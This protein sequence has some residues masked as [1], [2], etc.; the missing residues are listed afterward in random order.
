MSIYSFGS[1]SLDADARVLL[2]DGEPVPTAGKTLDTLLVL[3]KNAGRLIDKDEFLSLLWPDTVV[4][5]ANLTQ[6]ISTV[7]RVLGD[8][9][10]HHRYIATVA[11]RG[12]QFVAPVTESS[13]KAQQKTE[14]PAANRGKRRRISA[15]LFAIAISL[16]LLAGVILW[17]EESSH[18]NPTIPRQPRRLTSRPGVETMPAFSP[19]GGRLAYVHSER[20][21]FAMHFLRSQSA[22]ANIYIK[23]VEAGTE[24]QLTKHAGADYH[25]AW[26]ADGEYL[27]FYRYAPGGSGYYTISALGGPERRITDEPAD[28]AGIAWVPEEGRLRHLV[29]ASLSEGSHASP[30]TEISVETGD[31]R[32][33]TFPP[34]RTLGDAWPA[35]SP[36]GKTLA[37]ARIKDSNAFDICLMSVPQR[38]SMR[39]LPL[40]ASFPTGLA[41]TPA[42]N[43][44]VGTSLVGMA[45]HLWRY[46]LK[47]GSVS[48]LA[49]GIE[50][51]AEY[52]SVSLQGRLAFSLASRKADIWQLDLASIRPGTAPN[53][54]R[55]AYS[56]QLDADP[57]YSPDG[58]KIAFGSIRESYP[59][60]WVTEIGTQVSAQLTHL[61][62]TGSPSWSP[63]GMQIA[64]DQTDSKGRQIYI[65]A[66]GGG[67]PRQITTGVAENVVPSWSGDGK[68]VYFSSNRKGDFQI[69]KC[70]AKTGETQADP[71]V[72]VTQAGG[73]RAYESQDRNYLF[74]A[75]GRGRKGLWRRS[76]VSNSGKEESVYEALQEWGWWA[77][78][79][80]LVYFLEA[81]DNDNSQIRL[82]ALDMSNGRVQVLTNLSL[83]VLPGSVDLAISRDGRFLAFSQV[84]PMEADIMLIEK[85][86]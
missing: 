53:P 8:N 14:E 5:E 22:Q 43:A 40:D 31:R 58:H 52:P 82:Q 6:S 15:P 10:K 26:S 44:L 71:A 68:S 65:I 70:T 11:G 4:E 78:G 33:L 30:L 85:A 17:R 49:S 55:I 60:I 25:P 63:N 69:W 12:Y 41:W 56:S 75:K 19:D 46:E 80:R 83:P 57:S 1:F 81:P 3:V 47:S 20:D 36:D 38:T 64:F 67:E 9:P 34:A 16:V 66:A 51:A 74:Y 37:F 18:Q 32:Q 35:F 61:R 84:N 13:V 45:P 2:R 59:E 21:P 73:F 24:I 54:Q 42:G 86:D 79:P 77:L 27:A 48:F 29:V 50:G 23:L 62:G 39:C 76:L 28:S 7:R 72:Q